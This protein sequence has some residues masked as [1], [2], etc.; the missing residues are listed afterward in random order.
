MPRVYYIFKH[1][2]LRRKQNTIYIEETTDE[3]DEM[4]A[5]ADGTPK[6]VGKDVKGLSG[7]VNGRGQHEKNKVSETQDE[8]LEDADEATPSSSGRKV[9][10][11]PIPVEDIEE[12]YLFGEI[13]MNTKLLT[14]V[15]QRGIPMHVFSHYGWYSGTFY[16]RETNVSGH[17]LVRQV[18][19]YLDAQKRITIAHEI[20]AGALH[21]MHRNLLYYQRR[22]KDVHTSIELIERE[23]ANLSNVT[24][25]AHLR[26]IEGR[27]RDAYFKAFNQILTLSEPFKKRVRRPPD[28]LINALI[29]FGNSLLYSTTLAQ[30]YV[31]QLNP[32]IS[33]LHEPSERR[34]S[35]SLDI[36]D[37]FKPVIVDRVIFRVLNKGIIKE[38]DA[39]DIAGVI[40]LSEDAR[41]QF[42]EQWEAWLRTTVQHRRLKRSVSYRR[43][44]RLEC[45]KI[46]RHLLGMESYRA[47]R[48]WW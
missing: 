27:A 12:L 45:Y 34:F 6:D 30:I 44:I 43:M 11:R 5:D 31:T 35:L 40:A 1:G 39:E 16:P 4:L 2:R 9:M 33:Y 14:F 15:G 29:S 41:K 23:Q 46:I 47:L 37:I 48:V 17:L 8:H 7:E 38:S 21:N 10:R 13:D 18:E 25:I 20:V 26:G 28:N 42:I 19:H 32:T 36:A 22:G 24:E 3:E